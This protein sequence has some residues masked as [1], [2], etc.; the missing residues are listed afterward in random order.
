MPAQT[1]DLF[2][3][4]DLEDVGRTSELAERDLDALNAVAGWI[5]TFVAKPHRDLGRAGPTVRP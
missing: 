1:S 5:K 4:E 3:L 2:L